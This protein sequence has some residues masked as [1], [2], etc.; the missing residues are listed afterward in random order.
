MVE[1]KFW[2]VK[3]LSERSNEYELF[4]SIPSRYAYKELKY[5]GARHSHCYLGKQTYEKF[6]DVDRSTEPVEVRLV[7]T[8]SE[9]PDIYVQR[10]RD[11]L[12]INNRLERYYS[13]RRRTLFGRKFKILGWKYVECE[14]VPHIYRISN[15]LFPEIT[16]EC[17]P[18]KFNIERI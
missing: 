12:F 14:R 16:E 4:N 3:S 2:V 8:D 10:Y 13:P 5:W 1:N 9:T 7:P 11:C 6:A 15:K 17:G 18:V